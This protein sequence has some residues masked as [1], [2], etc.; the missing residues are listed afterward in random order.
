M[1]RDIFTH[2][3]I[4]GAVFGLLIFAA[5]CIFY[6]QHTTAQYKAETEK[7]HKL[8]QEWKAN[9]AKPP[10]TAETTSPQSPVESTQQNAEKP[11]LETVST[12]AGDIAIGDPKN[13]LVETQHS[14]YTDTVDSAYTDTVEVSPYGFGQYPEIPEGY[15]L[16]VSWTRLESLQE[17]FG[18][19]VCKTMELMGRVLIKL[20]NQGDTSFTGA[21]F[22]NGLVLPIYH[23]VAYVQ[24]EDEFGPTEDPMIDVHS[25]SSR[26]VSGSGLSEEDKEK[27]RK[28]EKPP[29]I[30][31]RTFYDGI[32]P[33]TFLELE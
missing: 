16:I 8:L 25:T 22:Q 2:K 19:D 6:Y 12:A 21:T 29:G 4:I 11:I 31:I 7:T 17:K 28:G 13:V 9:K 32:D 20:Y 26:I 15:Q 5:G 30:E 3:W 14:A 18:D 27:I 23:N 10:I 1:I 33:Y 24:L